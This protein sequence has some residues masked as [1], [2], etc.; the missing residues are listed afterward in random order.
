MFNNEN[1]ASKLVS[2]VQD[3]YLRAADEYRLLKSDRS[4]GKRFSPVMT[5]SMLIFVAT[6]GLLVVI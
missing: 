2:S 4:E 5:T 6:I 1:F 3:D